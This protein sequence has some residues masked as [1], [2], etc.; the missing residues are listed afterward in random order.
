MLPAFWQNLP[1][2]Q[3]ETRFGAVRGGAIAGRTIGAG[4]A[5]FKFS[6]SDY[7]RH[8]LECGA[9]RI[10]WRVEIWWRLARGLEPANASAL[11]K[12]S[13]GSPQRCAATTEFS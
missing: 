5:D 12:F 3:G 1:A 4:A 11:R 8:Q 13:I 9:R 6:L 2:K 7:A 10:Q